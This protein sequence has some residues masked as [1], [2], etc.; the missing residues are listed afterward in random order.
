MTES[1]P[2]IDGLH[3]QLDAAERDARLLVEELSEERGGWRA[4]ANSWQSKHV[5]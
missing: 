4:E 3:D 2:E 5:H 1:L